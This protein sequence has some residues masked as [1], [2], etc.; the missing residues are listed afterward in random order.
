MTPNFIM[1]ACTFISTSAL[2]LT[3][4]TAFAA[5]VSVG[6][7]GVGA[8]AD[9]GVQTDVETGVNA[10]ADNRVNSNVRSNSRTSASVD[11]KVDRPSKKYRNRAANTRMESRV[12]AD[13]DLDADLRPASGVGIDNSHRA[14]IENTIGL[15]SGSRNF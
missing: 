12:D 1:K 4:I 15:G 8:N 7:I 2:T 13:A 5:N 6:G 10:R 11:S 3:A 14:R 9:V